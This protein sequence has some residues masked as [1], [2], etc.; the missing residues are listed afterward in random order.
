MAKYMQQSLF[1]EL[2]FSTVKLVAMGENYAKEKGNGTNP[3]NELQ[4]EVVSEKLASSYDGQYADS[5]LAIDISRAAK[6]L[7]EVATKISAP[8]VES[9]TF[10]EIS[11]LFD[12]LAFT[13]KTF[14]EHGNKRKKRWF[15]NGTAFN[16]EQ[17]PITDKVEANMRH[18]L[19]YIYMINQPKWIYQKGWG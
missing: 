8:K 15:F 9:S 11:Y 6:A 14:D 1:D 10:E 5:D 4:L 7:I 19:V 18:Y 16:Y 2:V 12:E 13:V 3:P 17:L